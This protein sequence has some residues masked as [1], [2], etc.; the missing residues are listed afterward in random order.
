M[1]ILI[2][3][4]SDTKCWACNRSADANELAHYTVIGYDSGVGCG[5]VYTHVTSHYAGQGIEESVRSARPDLIW[6]GPDS[7]NG[8]K[9][10]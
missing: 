1:N 10:E 3:N 5:E 4:R 6:I 8:E 2:I 7:N 9:N